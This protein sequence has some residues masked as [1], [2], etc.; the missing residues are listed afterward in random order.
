MTVRILVGDALSQLATL[1]DESVH[2]CVSSPPYWNL[3][4]YG[5][6]PGMI[7]LEP[8]FDEHLENLLAVFREVW[9]VLR[10]DGTLWLNYGDSYAGGNGGDGGHG[11]TPKG[12]LIHKR[13]RPAHGKPK[14][15]MMMPARVA[16]ALQADGWWLRSEI[17]WAK[18]NPM[19]ESATDRPTSAHEKVFLLSKSARYFYDH[20]AVRTPMKEAS[21]ARLNQDNFENQTGGPKDAKIGNRSHRKTVENIKRRFD[22]QRGHSRRHA[23]F[24]DRWDAM[25][26]AEQQAGGAN[27]RN[28]WTV[29][30]H[31]FNGWIETVDLVQLSASQAR[32]RGA[33]GSESGGDMCRITS[34]DCPAHAGLPDHV[35]TG[36]CDGLADHLLSRMRG[37][38]GDLDQ[39]QSLSGDDSEQT[40]DQSQNSRSTP[41][42]SVPSDSPTATRSSTESHRTDPDLRTSP[43]A[44]ASGGSG[45]G[46][47]HIR[48]L[49]DQPAS[50]LHDTG[51]S[52]TEA[53]KTASS[54]WR[55]SPDDTVRTSESESSCEPCCCE[56]YRKVRS[57]TSHFAT[58]PPALIEPCIKAG[59]PA[60]GTVL[61]PFA[62]SGTVGLVA[63]RLGRDAVLIEINPEYAEM[64]RGRIVGDAPL[65]NSADAG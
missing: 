21:I 35:P 13:R 28:V 30:T 62:G 10:E 23:G 63:D 5:G 55:Q 6:D 14:D 48:P 41:D 49:P 17:V 47:G 64:A 7:G 42:C 65:L 18:P 32:E 19:P 29:A 39:G 37:S 54:S 11:A 24:N 22:K 8:T 26:K 25:S 38:G 59:C 2:C 56:H 51:A 33:S 36:F 9:R 16:M 57:K 15:L 3:R 27:L 1:P 12:G 20:V 61:D 4:S 34:P 52:K 53:D 43:R 31:P 44:I 40:R 45:V 46:T 60:S 50:M 58:F